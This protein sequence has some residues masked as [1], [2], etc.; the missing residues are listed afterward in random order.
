M[1]ISVS[2][3]AAPERLNFVHYLHAMLGNDV[4]VA[5]DHNHEGEWINCRRAWQMFN[6]AFDWHV[7][8]QDDAI[9]CKDFYSRL[10]VV[11][12][13][14]REVLQQD[15]F[16]VSFYY[17]DR[18]SARQVSAAA[19]EKGYWINKYPKWGVALCLPTKFIN[20]MI[21]Y[22]DKLSG[23]YY[24]TKDD[25]RMAK[26]IGFKKL[27]VYFPM[28]SLVNHRHGKSLVG[29]PGEKRQAYKFIDD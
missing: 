2:I 12:A 20:E 19:L 7:V 22:C 21:E 29:D 8:I 3:M 26:F 10:K 1:K 27:P 14:A 15:D 11:I 16:A 23:P 17:G 4:P 18:M 13:Q 28:P 9:I 5:M 6:S 25:A 24:G